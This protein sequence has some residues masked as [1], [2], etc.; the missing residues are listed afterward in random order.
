[1]DTS[2]N[3]LMESMVVWGTDLLVTT[4]ET[5]L[6][7]KRKKQEIDFGTSFG[8]TFLLP[9]KGRAQISILPL[10]RGTLLL[11]ICLL[12]LNSCTK[13]VNTDI[14]SKFSPVFLIVR[15]LLKKLCQ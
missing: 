11:L 12:D 9:G 4:V 10:K 2:V 1:M 5:D 13:M 3:T 14:F 8:P 7:A 15:P 6:A